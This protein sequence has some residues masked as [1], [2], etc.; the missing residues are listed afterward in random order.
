MNPG[1]RV[2]PYEIVGLIGAG[3]MGEVYRARDTRLDRAVAIK[4]L[5]AHLAD[6]A[7]AL[8]RFSQEAKAVA[9]LS[10]PNILALFDVGREGPMAYCVM[11]LLEG[12]PLREHLASGPLPPRKV[13][14]YGAQIAEGLA[15]AHDKGFVHRDLKPE[16]LF[17]TAEG[18][19]KILDFGL[20]K[21]VARGTPAADTP[22]RAMA[23]EPGVVVGTVGYMAPEQVRGQAADPRT[24]LFALGIVLHEL[25]S[26]R[27]PF[28]RDTAA[29]T[30]TAI[31]REDPPEL[32]TVDPQIPAGLARLV[33]HCLEKRPPER[34]QSARDL[35][36][37]LRALSSGTPSSGTSAVEAAAAAAAKR[38]FTQLAR[39]RGLAWLAGTAALVTL[40][41]V[42][43]ARWRAPTSGSERATFLDIGLPAGVEGGGPSASFSGDGRQL[44]FGGWDTHGTALWL[45]SL[46]SPTARKLPGTEG[47]EIYMQQP[48]WS[49]DNRYLIFDAENK[50]KRIE[51]ASGVVETLWTGPAEHAAI[52]GRAFAGDWN[53]QGDIL[54][55]WVDLY[56]LRGTGGNP[57]RIAT[58]APGDID[59]FAGRW[60]ADG[61]HYLFHVKDRA[62][63]RGGVFAGTLGSAERTSI[64]SIDSPAVFVEPGYLL[65]ER[66]GA[67]FAQPFDEARLRLLGEPRRL[68]E[69]VEASPWYGQSLWASRTTMAFARGLTARWQLT[70]FDRNGREA[71][72]VGDPLKIVTFDLSRDGS[73]V[74]ASIGDFRSARLGL[75]DTTRTSS[76]VGWLTDG[77]GDTDGR[78]NSD[79]E[80]VIFSG[81]DGRRQGLFRLSIRD[82]TSEPILT[83]TIEELSRTGVRINPHDWSRDDRW[84]LYSRSGGAI[85]AVTVADVS[86]PLV[87]EKNGL[88]D[89]ARFS[90]DGR[91]IAYNAFESSTLEG[92]PQVFVSSFPPRGERRRITMH[93]GVQPQ[94]RADGRE[95]YYL[96]ASGNLM[97]VDVQTGP[98]LKVGP[99]RL[100]FHT[101][102]S[103][104]SAQVEDYAVTADGQR[105]L[106]KLPA[107]G[108]ARPGFTVILNW[109]ALLADAR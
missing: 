27:A 2:G 69:R 70:W 95:L 29:E 3:G 55:S 31:L 59:L 20:A 89:Q 62:S 65:F 71:G 99:P 103:S 102:L 6:D 46:A 56:R 88:P 26:G 52:E 64:L 57:E 98:A 41:V 82:K 66:S 90:P 33:Q 61:R 17:L 44:V 10:H 47:A 74:V 78:F 50:V 30:M 45:R 109:P 54:F 107:E 63:G 86:R 80:E 108:E 11:E 4:V 12:A 25:L 77:P 48:I 51:V 37:S 34:F 24:D 38:P 13:I 16:N 84:A 53:D 49:P 87:V 58:R 15:A 35:A 68:V 79:G 92:I 21:E 104:V 67:L 39:W 9:A 101:G 7:A 106:V 43:G 1:S 8:A 28:A 76:P 40:G 96:D 81:R 60:L 75:I 19:A 72:R 73:R 22:T 42:A 5:P 83:Q 105:F 94:W 32:T 23:T 93:G 18:R 36:F 85:W 14:D 100:L 97:A 91:W